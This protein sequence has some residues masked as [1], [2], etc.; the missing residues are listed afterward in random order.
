[1]L[2]PADPAVSTML[3]VDPL[4]ELAQEFGRIQQDAVL[5]GRLQTAAQDK[6]ARPGFVKEL[7]GGAGMGFRQFF[8]HLSTSLSLPPMIP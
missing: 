4:V 7:Q 3:V 5:S 1:M 2:E 8:G 6:A